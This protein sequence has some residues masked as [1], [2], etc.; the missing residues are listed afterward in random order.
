MA[1]TI[2]GAWV[3][4]GAIVAIAHSAGLN[5]TW[6][7]AIHTLTLGALTTAIVVFSTHFT[8]ALTRAGAPDYE[9]VAWRVGLIQLGLLLLLAG[10]PNGGDFGWLANNGAALVAAAAIWHGAA[11]FGHLQR[12][13]TFSNPFS[14]TAWNFVAAACFLIVAVSLAV[15]AGNG[16]LPYDATISAHSRA[17]IWGFAW[18]TVLGAVITVLPTVTSTKASPAAR[19][20]CVRGLIAHSAGLAAAVVALATGHPRIAGGF[21]LVVA[22][23]AAVVMVPVLSGAFGAVASWTTPALSVAA[24]TVWLVAL[25]IA[26]AA[27]LLLGGVAREV[28]AD[29]LPALVG[30]SLLQLVTGV[31][32]YFLPT[33]RGG[34]P[35]VIQRARARADRFGFA[36]VAI[37][38]GGAL[39]SLVGTTSWH[40]AGTVILAVGLGLHVAALVYAVKPQD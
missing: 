9:S 7:Q 38:N 39:L 12:S 2:I 1:A 35:R 29:I 17:A 18:L 10:R 33:L 30:G 21:L 8:E 32:L 13:Q 23:A 40:V 34:G 3:V 19:T 6:W 5:V 20:W 37:M 22:I 4:G 11:L 36:R 24:G 31:L 28:T 16:W 27:T 26:D 15:A 25:C 14:P